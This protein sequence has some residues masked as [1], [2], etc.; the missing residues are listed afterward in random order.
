MFM[1]LYHFWVVQIPIH[2]TSSQILN[3]AQAIQHLH[4]I[5]RREVQARFQLP[6]FTPEFKETL[7][8]M[9]Q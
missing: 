7:Y 5:L 2:Y 6:Q 9:I 1:L 3:Q 4:Q 8:V